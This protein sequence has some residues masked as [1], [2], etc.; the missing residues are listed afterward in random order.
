VA[1]WLKWEPEVILTTTISQLEMAIKGVVDFVKK[2]NP[3]G[4]E[5]ESEE[6]KIANQ[7]ADPELAM[8]KLLAMAKRRQTNANRNATKPKAKRK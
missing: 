4:G 8:K 2:T 6:E 7:T 3:F 5:G 1:G